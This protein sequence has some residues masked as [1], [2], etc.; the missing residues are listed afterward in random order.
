MGGAGR[1]RRPA[2]WHSGQRL[3]GASRA[4]I[5]ALP[6][7]FPGTGVSLTFTYGCSGDATVQRRSGAT[8]VISQGGYTSVYALD[9]LGPSDWL[10]PDDPVSE[11]QVVTLKISNT[12]AT[13]TTWSNMGSVLPLTLTVDLL[14]GDLP[15]TPVSVTLLGQ[16]WDISVDC[17][18]YTATAT[19]TYTEEW[20]AGVVEADIAGMARYDA[21]RNGWEY[22]AGDVDTEA[23]TVT[24]SDVTGFSQWR[25]LA[26]TPP[27][28]V[29]DLSAVRSGSD[30][31]LTWSDVSEDIEGEAIS[32][33]TY[34]IYRA[35]NSPYFRANATGIPYD[36]T[37][38]TTYTDDGVVG[39]L[40]TNY[41]YVVTAVD[42][43]G[44]ESAISNRVGAYNLPA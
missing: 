42:T 38:D 44:R 21:G 39:D 24:I 35:A 16:V 36:T 18:G 7:P 31:V 3:D 10:P 32:G 25:I 5:P 13:T 20:L 34:N 8:Q 15:Y 1:S 6:L 11:G 43:A 30:L 23:N 4:V 14:D 22:V 9:V 28:S 40:D 2:R 12:L 17:T 19:F 33:V 27:E 29:S 37:G 26:S 41:Y